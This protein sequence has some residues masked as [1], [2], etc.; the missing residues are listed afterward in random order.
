[1]PG[2]ESKRLLVGRLPDPLPVAIPIPEGARVLGSQLFGP[3][4]TI[5]LD[6]DL[7]ESEVLAFYRTRLEAAGW[8]MPEQPAMHGGGFSPAWPGPALTYCRSTRGPS[9]SVQATAI[10]G[11]P[12]DVRLN[13]NTDRHQSACAPQPRP[14]RMNDPFPNLTPPDGAQQQPQGGGGGNS[15]RYSSASLRAALDPAAVGAHY[16]AQL[17]AAGWIGQGDGQSGPAAWSTWT[18]RDQDGEAWHGLLLA[19]RRL[20]AGD[21]YVL[22]LHAA[23]SADA[24]T[25]SGWA[26]SSC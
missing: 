22:Y 7:P 25:A 8:T 16:A 17:R 9:L 5:V 12:T 18:F 6:V 1:M 23:M 15:S 4:A 2:Y 26:A 10:E 19:L 21:D 3:I 13:L 24:G 20:E 14:G 11:S